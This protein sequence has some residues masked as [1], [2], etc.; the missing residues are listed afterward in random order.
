MFIA[1]QDVQHAIGTVAAPAT[2][3]ADYADNRKVLF[4]RYLQNINIL[5]SY[6]PAA[7]NAT[8]DISLEMS[9]DGSTWETIP[10]QQNTTTEIDMQTEGPPPI[11]FPLDNTSVIATAIPVSFQFTANVEYIRVSAKENGGSSAGTLWLD[12]I[13][14][15]TP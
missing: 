6:V 2:L 11:H 10:I 9:S 14:S 15:N 1:T 3:T 4:A 13:L 5:G 12:V 7:T 8:L